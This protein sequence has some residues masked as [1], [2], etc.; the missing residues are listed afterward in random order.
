MTAA[1]KRESDTKK[2]V[3]VI[4]MGYCL[5][6]GTKA[7]ENAQLGGDITSKIDKTRSGVLV[8]T[9]MCGLSAFSDAVRALIDKGH[10]KISPF[11]I[12]YTTTNM[13][14]ALPAIDLG[15]MGPNYSISTTCATSNYC[16]YAA[17]NHIRRGEV[18]VMI[19][20]GTEPAIIH[21]GLGVLESLEHAMKRDA[22]IIGEYLAG[23][24]NCDV[25]HMTDPRS[26]GLG[27]SS[28]IKKSLKDDGVSPEEINYI[29]A[30]ATSTVTGDFAE[31][32]AI[33]QVF[34]NPSGIKMN[35]TK[36]RLDAIATI[37]ACTTGWLHPTINQFN[38]ELSVEFDTVP[39]KKQQHEVNVGKT[40]QIT[41]P[42]YLLK[43][44]PYYCILIF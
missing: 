38:V 3:V 16:F 5:V 15:L 28:C 2:R 29:N 8:G 44:T 23:A 33:R 14:S 17:V 11:F 27:V 32:N 6:A 20:G 31:V 7:V 35:G 9:E 10:R 37:K 18:D 24:V 26:N 25:Y 39:N 19:A 41:S 36:G 4:K 13:A 1:P 22:P 12:P 43:I 21:I 40:S 34:K 42:I 30:H